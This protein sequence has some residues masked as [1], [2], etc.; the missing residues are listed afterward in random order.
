MDFGID[1]LVDQWVYENSNIQET[2]D[3]SNR[4]G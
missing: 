1:G 3:P 2:N 4:F